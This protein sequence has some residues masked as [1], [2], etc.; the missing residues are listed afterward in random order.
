MGM[1]G[2]LGQVTLDVAEGDAV[3]VFVGV[4]EHLGGNQLGGFHDTHGTDHRAATAPMS[5]NTPVVRYQQCRDH[6]RC[7]TGVGDVMTCDIIPDALWHGCSHLSTSVTKGRRLR[8]WYA[9]WYA[10]QPDSGGVHVRTPTYGKRSGLQKPDTHE[11]RR[12]PCLYLGVK[13]SALIRLWLSPHGLY[14]LHTI[15]VIGARPSW[16]ISQIWASSRRWS[17]SASFDARCRSTDQSG[18]AQVRCRAPTARCAASCAWQ[19]V[20]VATRCATPRRP[21]RACLPAF[22]SGRDTT[23]G[24]NGFAMLSPSVRHGIGTHRPLDGFSSRSS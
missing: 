24:A 8:A 17:R 7:N 5:S 2:Q 10:N 12:T 14:R 18:T 22:R 1:V 23:P 9:N 11:H 16:R 6:A 15:H 13:W 3:A 20:Q 19:T 4:L 21:S